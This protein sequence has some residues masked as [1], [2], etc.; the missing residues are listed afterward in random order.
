MFDSALEVRNVT[1]R[2]FIKIIDNNYNSN[3]IYR[4]LSRVNNE[5][6]WNKIKSFLEK[7]SKKFDSN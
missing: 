6:S 3:D 1:K 4:I 5:S 2:C 7:D